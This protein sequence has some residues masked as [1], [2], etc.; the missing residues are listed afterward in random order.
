MNPERMPRNSRPAEE[1]CPSEEGYVL[2]A[3]IIL[4]AVIMIFLAAAAPKVKDDIRR[5][6]EL[7]TMHRG[8]Q[9]SRAIQ[10]YYRR[11]RHYPASVDALED[12]N[13][14]RFLRKRYLDPLSGKD[15]WVP[16]LYGANKAPLTMGYFGQP[17]NMGAAVL[18][19]S[20]GIPGGD[21]GLGATQIP[22]A[23]PTS[24]NSNSN[25][26]GT[27][28]FSTGMPTLGGTGAIIGVSPGVDK[29]A[30]LVYKTKAHYT[31]WEFVYDPMADRANGLMPFP[32]QPAGPP[33]NF[34]A[35][36]FGPPGGPPV[37]PTPAPLRPR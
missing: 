35:P 32:I 25:G 2:A 17:L 14:T 28:A 10:L 6:Q 8:R 15:D 27:T 7:E 13:L 34:G 19:G 18:T 4:L 30:I 1:G 12:T 23:F 16:V 21:N 33:T 31:E 9:Y 22:T 24:G 20:A 37:A 3:V 26:S 36:G 5:D 29:D 11:L